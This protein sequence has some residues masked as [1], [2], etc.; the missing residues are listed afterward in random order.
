MGLVYVSGDHDLIGSAD[1]NVVL[2][3]GTLAG[4]PMLAPLADN[5]GSTMTHALLAG[6]PAIDTGNNFFGFATDQRGSAR[7]AG[8]APDIGAFELEQPQYDPVF[9]DGFDVEGTQ[10]AE[11]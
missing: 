4:N 3:P 10:G 9:A 2:P 5:G 11:P 7:L 8:P 6:S 1:S